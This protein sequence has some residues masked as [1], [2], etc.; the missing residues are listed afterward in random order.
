V[1]CA[2]APKNKAKKRAKKHVFKTKRCAQKPNVFERTHDTKKR[3]NTLFQKS[4]HVKCSIISQ[5]EN[6]RGYVA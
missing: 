4:L 6:A 3:N 1:F 5:V 2:N